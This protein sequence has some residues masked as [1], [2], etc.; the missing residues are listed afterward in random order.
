MTIDSDGTAIVDNNLNGE[1]AKEQYYQTMD[2]MNTCNFDDSKFYYDSG[3]K[4]VGAEIPE[5]EMVN[6]RTGL[7]YAYNMSDCL[8]VPGVGISGTAVRCESNLSN[9]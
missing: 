2:L 1:E 7:P 8:A 5:K 9:L 4:G 3:R 6:P